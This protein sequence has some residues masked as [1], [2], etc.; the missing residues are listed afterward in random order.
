MS[1]IAI[2]VPRSES[3]ETYFRKLSVKMVNFF[4]ALALRGIKFNYL[5]NS[6]MWNS[7]L[8]NDTG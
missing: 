2:W 3:R 8:P 6:L 5:E 4:E 1:Q 7:S